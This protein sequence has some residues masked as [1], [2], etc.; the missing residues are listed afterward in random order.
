MSTNTSFSTEASERYARALYEVGKDSSD[1]EKIEIDVK[2]FKSLYDNNIEIKP[3]Y[4]GFKGPIEKISNNSYISKGTYKFIN[5]NTL[6][7]T[8]LPVGV[9]T[10]KYMEFL[11]KLSSNKKN[12]TLK[13]Y[14][15]YSTESQVSIKLY[16]HSYKLSELHSL[17]SINGVTGLEKYLKLTKNINMTNMW[18][19]NTN[20]KIVKY[21]HINDIIDEWFH[22]RHSMYEKRK[23]YLVA[24]L[25]KELD[26]IK[27]KVKF[28]NEFI[29]NTIEIRNKTKQSIIDMLEQKG[30][31]KINIHTEIENTNTDPTNTNYDYLLKMNLYNLTKEEVESL[32]KKRDMKQ[33]ELDT[34]ID[35]TIKKM[36]IKEIN[37][38]IV[39][40]NKINTQ[41]EKRNKKIDSPTD[42]KTK[43]SKT[44]KS[45]TKKSK[46]KK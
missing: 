20:R 17:P 3:W 34:L 42:S 33:A 27:Y 8:E 22:Y 12:K 46:T 28:I 19:F 30:Y 23:K 7:I 18:L 6:E 14:T 45:K 35:M 38:C 26:I 44:K 2:K 32:T 37:G 41:K 16:F 39:L 15:D 11:N 25:K 9:W 40:Y 21:N 24:K 36:W 43:K 31:P 5:Q 13:Y 4:R 29:N 10:E 1:L